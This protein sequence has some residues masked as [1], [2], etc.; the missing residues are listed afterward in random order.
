MLIGLSPLL[1]GE[2]YVI[3]RTADIGEKA[4]VPIQD[5]RDA[6]Y[7][8]GERAFAGTIK[9]S[10]P[11]VNDAKSLAAKAVGTPTQPCVAKPQRTLLPWMA[12]PSRVSHSE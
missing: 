4:H 9:T 2:L 12:T 8:F 6:G 10:S 3:C 5:G 7:I 11:T 1:I